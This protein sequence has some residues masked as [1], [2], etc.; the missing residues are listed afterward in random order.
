M[1]VIS[2]GRAYPHLVLPHL[3]LSTKDPRVSRECS[4][5]RLTH[6]ADILERIVNSS[7]SERD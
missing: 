7:I 6:L 5:L 4:G 1:R 2:Y 3:A